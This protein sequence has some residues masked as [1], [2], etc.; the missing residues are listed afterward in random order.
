MASTE[1]KLAAAQAY[2]DSHDQ[3]PATFKHIISLLKIDY[4]DV[5]LVTDQPFCYFAQLV[6]FNSNIPEAFIEFIIQAALKCCAVARSEVIM[7]V[8]IPNHEAGW[9]KRLEYVRS[10]PGVV[11]TQVKRSAGGS[12]FY[13]AYSCLVP[14]P[15]FIESEKAP[16]FSRN[17]I[18]VE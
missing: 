1:E 14:G 18:R 4:A 12:S 9:T 7:Q 2:L 13:T 6:G 8:S 11:V 10:L 15:K 5:R 3:S 17:G 16:T